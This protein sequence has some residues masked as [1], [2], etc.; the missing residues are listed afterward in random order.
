V[1]SVNDN[2]GVEVGAVTLVVN[3]GTR[4]PELKEVTVPPPPPVPGPMA[5]Q[6]LVAE[7]YIYLLVVKSQIVGS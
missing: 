2:A 1:E 4:L 3:S 5:A 7:Q 6:V